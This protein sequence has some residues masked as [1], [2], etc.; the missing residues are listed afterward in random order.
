MHKLNMINTERAG[1]FL[2]APHQY[3]DL[4]GLRIG[5][6]DYGEGP[7]LV[8]LH[9]WP[10]NGDTF[11]SVVDAIATQCR[12]IVPDLPGAGMTRWSTHHDLSPVGQARL[13]QALLAAL[14]ITDYSLLGNDSGGMVARYLAGGRESP[15]NKLV[16]LN[17]EIPRHRAPYQRLYKCLARWL[18]GYSAIARIQLKFDA[19]LRSRQ[20]FG[21][22]LYNHQHLLGSFNRRFILP[23]TR[24]RQRMNEATL[25]FV[26]MLNW[27]QLD[28]LRYVHERIQAPT[29]F[30]W[31][32]QD[33]TF[34]EA[35][36]VEMSRSFKKLAGFISIDKAKLYVH[37][38]QP[39]QVAQHLSAFL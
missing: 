28:E 23:L 36:A 11:A 33:D 24:S 27:P 20:G 19:Y 15:V 38:D 1:G 7:V 34:P 17:T 10:L 26:A 37:E 13:I 2:A 16:L 32:R 12:C 8:M 31:G 9:G 6:R 25:S 39:E 22:T 4:E 29:L 3:A 35:R 30:I 14:N 18:P 21:G 5:Y